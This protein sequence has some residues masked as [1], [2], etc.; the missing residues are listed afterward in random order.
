MSWDCIDKWSETVWT[1]SWEPEPRILCPIP[2]KPLPLALQ[3]LLHS[4]WG[5]PSSLELC[6]GLGKPDMEKDLGG[7]GHFSPMYSLPL[8]QPPPGWAGATLQLASVAGPSGPASLLQTR[9]SVEHLKKKLLVSRPQP[10]RIW[11]NWSGV[12]PRNQHFSELSRWLKC[13]LRLESCSPPL[14][15]LF[16]CL[17]YPWVA[18]EFFF[19][20]SID[21]FSETVSR[22]Y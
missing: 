9:I 3:R 19:F 6:W 5:H 20:S 12:E 16:L 15:W 2:G 1:P 22:P 13:V 8:P 21:N 11:S 18:L 17:L 14:I 7:S 10:L 4:C